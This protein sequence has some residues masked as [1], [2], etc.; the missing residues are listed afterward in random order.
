MGR[1]NGLLRRTLSEFGSDTNIPSG[2]FRDRKVTYTIT[3]DA[4]GG[5]GQKLLLAP[6]AE[7]SLFQRSLSGNGRQDRRRDDRL[8]FTISA[9]ERAKLCGER[10]HYAGNSAA[11]AR[12]SIAWGCYGNRPARVYSRHHLAVCPARL[13]RDR[14]PEVKKAAQEATK[15]ANNMYDAAT[16]LEDY[17]RTFKYSTKNDDPPAGQDAV[18]WF[19]QH[20]VGFCTFFASAMT[21]MARSL[22]M[23]ARMAVGFTSGSYDSKSASYIVK[24]SASHAWT[25]IYFAK[26]GWVNFEPTSSFSLFPRPSAQDATSTPGAGAGGAGATATPGLRDR[27]DLGDTPLGPSVGPGS[28]PVV[29]TTTISLTVVLLLA[30]L[31]ALV[32]LIWWR[33]LFRGLPRAA[34]LFG[35]VTRLG[36]WAGSP[37][38]SAQTPNEYAT[39][40]GKFVPEEQ[41]DIKKLGEAYTLGRWGDRC[42][43]RPCQRPTGHVSSRTARAH[44]QDH[45]ARLAS[46]MAAPLVEIAPRATRRST[47]RRA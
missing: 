22:G 12:R 9:A 39:Q 32:G 38:E 4:L 19:L 10:L 21:L 2:R 25:Q 13:T 27:G 7:A 11:T 20:Q 44:T 1:R 28:S 45:P 14:A 17:L 24:E 33:S 16:A 31:S 3:Y 47:R 46:A 36:G 8:A 29:I 42:A 43:I 6:G 41:E 18:V 15:G 30:L 23:P 37:P 35:R 40:L 34:A 5:S 26:Y